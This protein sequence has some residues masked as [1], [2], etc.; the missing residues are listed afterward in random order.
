VNKYELYLDLFEGID[1]NSSYY[2]FTSVGRLYLNLTKSNNPIRWRRLL[3]QTEKLPNMQLWWDLHEK[4]EEDLLKH[5]T[6]ETDEAME[7]LISYGEP[8][9]KKKKKDTKKK[10]EK[11][12]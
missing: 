11:E 6:F 10:K 5:T 8:P 2:E 7:N 1:T 3:K 9:K 4:Y 12:C